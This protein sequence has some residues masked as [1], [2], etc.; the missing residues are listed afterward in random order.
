MINS[1]FLIFFSF[2]VFSQAGFA[3]EKLEIDKRYKDL[4]IFS[5]AL[6]II[7]KYY[8]KDIPAEILIQGA[9]EGMVNKL[10]M[11]SHFMSPKQF[12]KFKNEAQGRYN[13]FGMEIIFKNHILLVLSVL[14]DS[15][16]GKAGIKTGHIIVE[17]NKK[18]TAE[19][20]E[21]NFT[22]VFK[23]RKSKKIEIAV[24]MPDS[25]SKDLLRVQ[26]KPRL[27]P[28]KSVVYKDLKEGLLYV[29]INVFTE[30]TLSE[31][32]KGIKKHK[33][34]TGLILDLR[35]NP[36]GLFQSAVKV[37]DLFIKKGT[38]VSVKG[39]RS[40]YEQIFKAQTIGTLLP[41]PIV[42][43]IDSGSASAAEIVAGA[44]KE[45]KRAILL[46]RK[47]FGKGSVQSL[48]KIDEDGS[49]LNLTVAHYYTPDGNSI[50]GKGIKPHTKLPE[51]VASESA[52]SVLFTSKE[53]TDFQRA[54]SFLKMSNYFSA[55]LKPQT[56][57]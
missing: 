40:Q 45:N 56:G 51:P 24:R 46:G 7:E 16:A 55:T 25:A 52:G 13:G 12:K 31:I 44:L 35:G 48:I 54:Y 26:L 37:A 15:P 41:F 23:S 1:I 5:E 28:L 34:P 30:R 27:I 43:L 17:I 36:G 20:T 57:L 32:L 4:K 8:V 6:S 38:I 53:D 42:V 9:V 3:K 21:E 47:S 2:F 39:R 11:H 22:K 29:R 50:H 18:K 10:D 19:L 33:N 14:K 49:A